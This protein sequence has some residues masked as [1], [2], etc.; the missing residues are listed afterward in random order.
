[1]VLS[2]TVVTTRP[3]DRWDV[4][5]NETYFDDTERCSLYGK[6]PWH[7]EK[8]YERDAGW[9]CETCSR[10]NSKCRTMVE[11]KARRHET[12]WPLLFLIPFLL[13]V[14]VFWFVKMRTLCQ[15]AAAIFWNRQASGCKTLGNSKRPRVRVPGAPPTSPSTVTIR[16]P[17]VRVRP[18]RRVGVSV[19]TD[20]HAPVPPSARRFILS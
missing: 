17:R 14:I 3:Y 10:G 13:P 4:W 5:A 9:V 20:S 16:G 7:N 11:G 15:R 6:Q 18:V 1:M 2:G 19:R 12:W 8:K